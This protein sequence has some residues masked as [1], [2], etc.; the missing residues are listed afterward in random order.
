[1][2][3]ILDRID[4]RNIGR[5]TVTKCKRNDTRKRKFVRLVWSSPITVFVKRDSSFLLVVQ[6]IG[7][8]ADYCAIHLVVSIERRTA[9]SRLY[10]FSE[11]RIRGVLVTFVINHCT[12]K[13]T[14]QVIST[15]ALVQLLTSQRLTHRVECTASKSIDTFISQYSV[16]S[17][18]R[19]TKSVCIL[20]KLRILVDVLLDQ[21]NV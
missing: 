1:M 6:D 17:V 5:R 9:K 16:K 7:F 15:T 18:K 10:H 8:A 20:S 13:F 2:S 4:L 12:D 14:L 19:L 21:R 3:K 11:G